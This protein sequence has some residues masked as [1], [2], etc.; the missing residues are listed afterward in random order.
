MKFNNI[1]LTEETVL[2]TRQHFADIMQG[3][4]DE[5]LR[6]DVTLA[7][8]VDPKDYFDDCDK[9]ANM[10]LSGEIDHNF[11]F[12]QRAYWIQTGDCVVM[13]P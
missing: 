1:E 5:V 7:S 6:G 13:L 10:Y 4:I 8:H 9:R 2:L 3:C 11:T 12:L